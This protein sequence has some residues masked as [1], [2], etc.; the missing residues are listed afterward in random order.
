MPKIVLT[1]K[2]N[3]IEAYPLT[4]DA[5]IT[6]GRHPGNDIVIDNLAVSGYHAAVAYEEDTGWVISDLDSKN[7]TFVN[8]QKVGNN[9]LAHKDAISIGKHIL[10]VDLDDTI[11]VGQ[12][13]GP[14]KERPGALN[15]RNTMVLEGPKEESAGH[16]EE[17]LV[18]LSRPEAD[19]LAILNGGEGV[20]SL[21]RK[22][23]VSIG[24]NQDADIV[25]GG[26]W[27]FLS[28]S[29]AV[30]IIKQAGDYFLRYA[31][32]LIKPK[33]NGSGVRGTIK[34]NNNDVISVGPVKVRVQL[35]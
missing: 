24:R 12:T 14:V 9:S 33:R 26:F 10:L 21:S 19:T 31:G 28:G 29:P 22:G 3:V 1:F 18:H 4:K 35:R 16:E 32:G 34:L 23:M 25:I 15:N 17:P 7:G 5:K 11:D 2:K 6:I 27:G 8:D 20:I 13:A 30:T